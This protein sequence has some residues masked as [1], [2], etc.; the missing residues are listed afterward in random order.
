MMRVLP[1][2][3]FAIAFAAALLAAQ[4]ISAQTADTGQSLASK[5]VDPSAG[6]SSITVQ[7]KAAFTRWGISN[8]EN[9]V[10]IQ[11]VLPWT[12]AGHLNIFR[13]RVPFI[14]DNV[15][16]AT[17]LDAVQAFNLTIFP[18]GG[19]KV[20][21]GV[22]FQFAPDRGQQ[23]GNFGIGPVAGAVKSRH[24]WTYGLL[25]QN[26][27]GSH[28]AS[29]QL[30]PI[31]AKTLSPKVSM[32]LGDL[33]V[34]YDWEGGRWTSLPIGAQLNYITGLGRQPIRLFVN[35]QYNFRNLTGASQF[36]TTFGLALLLVK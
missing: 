20:L 30:Q 15:P 1:A 36:S 35:P 33:Q 18:R 3:R 16:G 2:T 34:A 28:I 7:D 10:D 4:P 5:V 24:G 17:G 12:A 11:P 8:G 13:V 14:T 23:A 9:E 19:V 31:L 21:F 26:I 22:L 25:N 6:L 29:S 32:A 27:F